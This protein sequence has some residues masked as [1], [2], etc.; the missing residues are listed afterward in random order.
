MT[1]RAQL[2]LQDVGRRSEA[3]LDEVERAIVGKRG[4]L[5]LVLCALLAD[6]HVLVEDYPGLGKTLIAR[7]FA[8]VVSARFTRV[9]P[10]RSTLLG[11]SPS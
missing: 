11:I 9:S 3:I 1:S 10:L 8:T 7:S 6:G 5:E 4:V 2:S